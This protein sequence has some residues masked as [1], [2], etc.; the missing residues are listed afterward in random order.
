FVRMFDAG[1]R[2]VI[3][4]GDLHKIITSMD[5][6]DQ[7]IIPLFRADLRTTGRFMTHQHSTSLRTG[8]KIFEDLQ[9]VSVLLR[10]ECNAATQ[11]G[12]EGSGRWKTVISTTCSIDQRD[13]GVLAN[14]FRSMMFRQ[15]AMLPAVIPDGVVIDI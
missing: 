12:A 9:A 1:G 8:Y 10:A 5:A 13:N 4:L 15:H 3:A 2:M 11:Y 14:E 6:G 7:G